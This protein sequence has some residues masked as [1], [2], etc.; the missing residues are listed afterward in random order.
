MA[1]Y[2]EADELGKCLMDSWLFSFLVYGR[3][4]ECSVVYRGLEDNYD[5]ENF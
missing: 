5:L 4:F 2:S 1:T 3:R